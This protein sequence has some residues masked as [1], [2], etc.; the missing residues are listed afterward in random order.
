MIVYFVQLLVRTGLLLQPNNTLVYAV[1]VSIDETANCGF[2]LQS[3]VPYLEDLTS[4]DI[5]LFPK[6]KSGHFGNNDVDLF[7]VEE[8]SENQDI[9]VI[10]DRIAIFEYRWTMCVDASGNYI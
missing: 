7:T 2:K 9:A 5:F 8:F 4:S 6:L 3:H 10:Y 1:Q